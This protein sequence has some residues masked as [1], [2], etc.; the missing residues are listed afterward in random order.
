MSVF[1]A[2]YGYVC[3]CTEQILNDGPFRFVPDDEFA[4]LFVNVELVKTFI[5]FRSASLG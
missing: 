5:L 4:I 1:V 3:V 2:G